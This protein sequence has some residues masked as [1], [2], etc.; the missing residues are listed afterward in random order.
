MDIEDKLKQELVEGNY[1]RLKD[2]Y[3][4]AQL[5]CQNETLL[6]Q[7]SEKLGGT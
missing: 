5:T 1:E 7:A 3:G 4:K 6:R 2:V